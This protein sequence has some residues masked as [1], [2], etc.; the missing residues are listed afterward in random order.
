MSV[1]IR[2]KCQECTEQLN[3]SIV[4][5]GIKNSV[6]RSTA[7]KKRPSSYGYKWV[8]VYS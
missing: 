5:K 7:K 3:I 6:K 8:L 1:M 2:I 4:V